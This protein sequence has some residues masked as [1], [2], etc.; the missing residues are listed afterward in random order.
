MESD[1]ASRIPGY[2]E[3]WPK[4]VTN[5]AR[6]VS[7]NHGSD[8]RAA[9]TVEEP[10]SLSGNSSAQNSYASSASSVSALQDD[11]GYVVAM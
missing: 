10:S 1:E 4:S 6:S 2:E 11:G 7:V 9:A 3:Y 8:T 5:S